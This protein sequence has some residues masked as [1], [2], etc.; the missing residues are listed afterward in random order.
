M[1]RSESGNW[2]GCLFKVSSD[3]IKGESAPCFLALD[4]GW[5]RGLGG[6]LATDG[7]WRIYDYDHN[8]RNPGNH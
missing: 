8:Y 7:N 5:E 2:N 4:E 1:I 6:E 3:A